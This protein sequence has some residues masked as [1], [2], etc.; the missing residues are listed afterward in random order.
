MTVEFHSTTVPGRGVLHMI[1][2]RSGA[3]LGVLVDH[4]GTRTILTYGIP[5]DD[6]DRVDHE[7]PLTPDEADHLAELLHSPSVR[8]RLD[9]LERAVAQLSGATP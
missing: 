4:D 5:P 1:E 6:P 8:E 3:R 2:T 7:I 9:A